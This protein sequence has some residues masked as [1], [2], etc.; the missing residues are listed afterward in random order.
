MRMMFLCSLMLL[1]A[2]TINSQTYNSLVLN[3]NSGTKTMILT[4]EI[5]SITYG[6]INRQMIWT[7][8]SL[9]KTDISVINSTTF[10][11]VELPDVLVKTEDIGNWSEMRIHKDGSLISLKKYRNQDIP[12]EGCIIMPNET[13]GV[14]Y[15]TFKIDENEVPRYITIN[16]CVIL[17]DNYYDNYVDITLAYND[18][19]AYS[20]DSIPYNRIL[21]KAWSENNWQRN[22]TGIIEIA[23]G[24]GSIVGGSLLITGSVI[25]ETGSLGASTPI[26]IPGILAGSVTIAGGVSSINTGWEKLFIPGASR[27]NI[28]ETIYYQAAGELIANG[29][30]NAYVPE[31]YFSYM[32]DPNYS[33]QLGKAGWI[34][35]LVG[36]TSGMFDNLFGRT[37]TWED[38]RKYYQGK[39]ITGLSENITSNSA[40]IRGYIS[41]DI[42]KSLINGSKIENEYGV[43]LYSTKDE[44]E[45]CIQKQING[46]GGTIEYDFYNLKPATRYNYRVFYIDKTNGINLLGE[47]KEF[48]TP[49]PTVLDDLY[50]SENCLKSLYESTSGSSWT[51]NTG[52]FEDNDI[53]NWYGLEIDSTKVSYNNKKYIKL[54]LFQN[55]LNGSLDLFEC[56]GISYLD[57]RGNPITKFNITPSYGTKKCIGYK[58]IRFILFPGN[59][60]DI[61]LSVACC[62]SV[63]INAANNN[64]GT[65]NLS[66]INRY[67][68]YSRGDPMDDYINF[69]NEDNKGVNIKNFKVIDPY[70]NSHLF[71]K[72]KP[73]ISGDC[74]LDFQRPYNRYGTGANGVDIDMGVINNLILKQCGLLRIQAEK[75]GTLDISRG[76]Y[77]F[78]YIKDTQIGTLVFQG[79]NVIQDC[80]SCLDLRNTRCDKII[81]YRNWPW[82]ITSDMSHTIE[83]IDTYFSWTFWRSDDPIFYINEDQENTYIVKNG[84]YWKSTSKEIDGFSF[85]G[86][87]K[88]L[89]KYLQILDQSLEN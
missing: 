83:L 23:S 38:I 31:Q 13:L 50:V 34:N 47:T 42:T 7:K 70:C 36:L 48:K 75:I 1:F 18:S 11:K 76:P 14:L 35:C 33:S 26:S 6:G 20:L 46:N 80:L 21:T 41:P 37:V 85:E 59:G 4:N 81:F 87:L 55:N 39:V 51:N 71:I 30:Q 68:D 57:F 28:G 27:S 22:L 69:F 67:Q 49:E 65:L 78:T 86:T 8:D 40:T 82:R 12:A 3:Q 19:I 29:P 44:T 25:T 84:K 74:I 10:E 53:N 77:D 43:A 60:E 61:N 9:Y 16:D 89:K 88:E 52:W 2:M 64:I 24:A 72:G 63:V 45:R 15:S 32:K 58:D 5:D 73:N 56:K 54:N 79:E 66:E 17:V 62:D